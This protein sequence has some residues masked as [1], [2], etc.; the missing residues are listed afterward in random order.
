VK[1]SACPHLVLY[2]GYL[3]L[4]GTFAD[5]KVPVYTRIKYIGNS[6]K[7]YLEGK[8]TIIPVIVKLLV[9]YRQLSIDAGCRFRWCCR[10]KCW[11]RTS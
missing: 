4:E 10:L 2:E 6:I 3:T 11:F 5:L 1:I 7:I 9:E 8:M